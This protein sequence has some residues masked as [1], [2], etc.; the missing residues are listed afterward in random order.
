VALLG[1]RLLPA[2]HQWRRR[3]QAIAVVAT[4]A[5]VVQG[6][7]Q[8]DY[9]KTVR[10]D[11]DAQSGIESDLHKLADSGAFKSSCVPISVPNHRAV[12]RLAAWLGL[13]PSKI[14]S[15]T[16]QR[17]P[18]HGYFLD[19]ATPF[20]VHHFVLDPNDPRRLT[21]NPPPGF[22]VAARNDSWK[23]YARCR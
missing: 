22:T 21:S 6:H 10:S 23:L 14:I 18:D 1:W 3:W 7:Q 11:L 2:G 9:L 15:S 13:R 16:E 8:F 5:F 17:Q 19:P 4:L 20:V 12:P